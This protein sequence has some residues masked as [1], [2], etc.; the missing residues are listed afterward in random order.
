MAK[1]DPTWKSRHSKDPGIPMSFPLREQILEDIEAK[2]RQ[3]LELKAQRREERRQHLLAQGAND[4]ELEQVL[5][6]EERNDNSNRLAALLESAEAAAA[7]YEGEDDDEEVDDDMEIEYDEEIKIDIEEN[8]SNDTSRKA[9]DK[10]YKAVL[11]RSDVI[12]YVLDARDPE[13]TRSRTV[14]QAVLAKPDKRLLFVL[15][16]I[17]LVSD[18]VLKEWHS[19]LK[20]QF[21]TLPLAASSAAPNARTFIHKGLTQQSTASALVGALKAYANKSNLK[22][23]ITV[24]IIGYPNVG[25]SSVIN[26]ILT[27]HGGKR[28]ACPVG[29][30]AGIT[31]TIRQIKVDTKLRVLDSPGV[32]FPSTESS[33]SASKKKSSPVDEQSRLVL[34]NAL[35][36]KQIDDPVPAV[37]LLLKRLF[38]NPELKSYLQATYGLPPL[39]NT[40]FESLV[41]DFLV[42]VARKKGRLGKGGIPDLMGAAHAIIVDWRDGRITGWTTPKETV[43]DVLGAQAEKE[44]EKEALVIKP[45]FAGPAEEKKVVAEWA[46]EFSL[47]GLWDGNFGD[48]EETND[49]EM[50]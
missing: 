38:S 42:Q 7:D 31:T 46:T 34:L 19:V 11:D 26:S 35:P 17:D 14:E 4:E 40:S 22:R 1:K 20:L 8:G 44:K 39:L 49:V 24:G 21:P 29:A 36:P 33:T 47:E 16:K 37:S 45:A 25:K 27:R 13:G 2:K 9:F 43:T 6:N 28:T 41:T 30:Q 5:E 32:V 10:I 3:D 15:N 18:K 48:E 23:A 12:L 50:S